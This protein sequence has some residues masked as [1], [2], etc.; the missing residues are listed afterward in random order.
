MQHNTSMTNLAQYL[1][2]WRRGA[3]LLLALVSLVVLAVPLALP[4]AAAGPSVFPELISLPDGFRPE[5][6]TTGRGSTFFAGSLADGRIY[7]GD[8]R[9]GEGEVL[10]PGVGRPAV[11]LAYDSRSNYLFVAGGPSGKASVYDAD[12]GQEVQVYDLPVGTSTFVNDVVVTRD[13]AYFTDS[14]AAQYYVLPLSAQGALPDASQVETIA[15]SG[16]F[17]QVGGFNSNGIE[18]TPNGDALFI[19]NSTAGLLFLVDPA[20]GVAQ[21][22]DLGNGME[23]PLPNGDGILLAG[24][25]M[26]VVQNQLNQIAVVELGPDF[27]SGAV[28]RVIT[29]DNFDIPTTVAGFG[30]R[31]YAV[32]ARFSTPP[33][34]TTTYEVVQVSKN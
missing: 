16:D 21:Q 19:V 14:F 29:N 27:S 7:K 6:I 20:T 2:D 4:A 22:I 10:V 24:K 18:A 31:L 1:A 28:A 34:P 23:P 25:T 3:R 32:N 13:A 12:T 26:Y 17:V 30:S 11:G 9:T 5:G 8:Y 15:L 33:T